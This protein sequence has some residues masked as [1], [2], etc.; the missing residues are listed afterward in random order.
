MSHI[1]QITFVKIT[2]KTFKINI[3]PNLKILDVGSGDYHGSSRNLFK[4]RKYIGVDIQKVE[5]VDKVVKVNSKLPF[6]DKKFDLVLSCNCFEHNPFWKKS[7][8]EMYR[9]LKNGKFFIVSVPSRGRVEHGTSRTWKGNFE[10]SH[11]QKYFKKN[12]NYYKNLN[13][14]DFLNFFDIK[15]MFKYYFFYNYTDSKDLFFVGIKSGN[16]NEKKDK[17]L[18]VQLN[19]LF[20]KIKNM[21]KYLPKKRTKTPV[22]LRK[23]FNITELPMKFL[24]LILSDKIYQ[25]FAI[26]YYRFINKLN[27][28]MKKMLNL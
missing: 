22:I 21:N 15:K 4:S 11:N 28:K 20:K 24:S 8:S 18:K 2:T 9:T 19:Q 7:F 10:N 25:E 5:G 17:K 6:K 26:P 13:Q 1:E 27:I 3:D 12:F 23:L 14:S 16:N